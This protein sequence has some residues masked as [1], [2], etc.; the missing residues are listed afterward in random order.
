MK[1]FSDGHKVG[2]T[3]AIALGKNLYTWACQ[4]SWPM[5]FVSLSNE[6]MNKV[7][8]AAVMEA[9]HSSVSWPSTHHDWPGYSFFWLPSLSAAKTHVDELENGGSHCGTWQ[10]PQSQATASLRSQHEARPKL[11]SWVTSCFPITDIQII[12]ACLRENS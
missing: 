5:F 3:W 1:T 7:S 10:W 4:S 12:N 11:L 6:C 8:T 2:C 9:A